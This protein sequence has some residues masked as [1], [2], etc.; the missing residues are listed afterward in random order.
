M[1]G[2]NVDVKTIADC[3]LE[4][5]QVASSVDSSARDVPGKDGT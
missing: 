5:L 2:A 1:V 3:P 4:E